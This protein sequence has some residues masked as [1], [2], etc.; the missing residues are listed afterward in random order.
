MKKLS[1]LAAFALSAA[2][3]L[4]GCNPNAEDETADGTGTTTETTATDTGSTTTTTTTSGT[5]GSGSSDST[6]T[7]SDSGSTTET[8]VKPTVATVSSIALEK[9]QT[10][11]NQAVVAW[12]NSTNTYIA[13]TGDK[14]KFTI[15]ATADSAGGELK[16][17]LVDNSSGAE[18]WWSMLSG[19]VE[20]GTSV[21]TESTTY[22]FEFTLTADASSADPAACKLGLYFE[23]VQDE[24]VT[25]T[26]TSFSVE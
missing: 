26:V 13:K 14:L 3:I 19:Y 11:N 9:N 8:T 10:Y 2:L 5:S 17:F 15:T 1:I 7:G 22:T 4:S 25:L 23:P 12:L 18:N 21:A 16:G 20:S 24:T 6:D